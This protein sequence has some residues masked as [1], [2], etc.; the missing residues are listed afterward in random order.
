MARLSKKFLASDVVDGT[1][2]RFSNNEAF[3]LRNNADSADVE[4]YKLDT[5]D[6]FQFLT[7][8]RIS[9]TASNDNDVLTLKDLNQ[10]LEGLKPKAACRVATTA[11][12]DISSAPAAIDGITLVIGDRVL[13]KDQSVAAQNGIRIFSGAAG[14]MTRS[15]DM[16]S[17][18]PI[19]EVNGAYTAVQEGTDNEGKFFSQ[20]GTVTTIDVDPI[21]FVFFNSVTDLVGGDGIDITGNTISI[22]HDGEG[23][24]FNAGVLELEL[25]GAT[26]SKSATGIK[27]ADAG[28]GEAQLASDVDA[29]S[30]DIAVGYTPGA[31]TVLPGDTIQEALQKVDGTAGAKQDPVSGGDGIDVTADVVSVDLSSTPYLEFTSG[32]LQAKVSADYIS[33]AAGDVMDAADIKT[34]VDAVE[35]IANGKQDPISGADAIDVTADV[36]SLTLSVGGAT[37]PVT[38][39]SNTDIITT[40]NPD[41]TS[42][43]FTAQGGLTLGVSP[44]IN[45]GDSLSI[46][47]DNGDVFTFDVGFVFNVGGLLGLG[48]CTNIERNT[49][50]SDFDSFVHF[51]SEP[52]G[53]FDLEITSAPSSDS[54]LD[55][56]SGLK[57]LV[58]DDYASATSGELMDAQD[59][60]DAIAATTPNVAKETFV[61]DASDIS[62]G[63]VDLAQTPTAA[64]VV[65]IV[66]GAVPQIEGIDFSVASNRVTFLGDLASGGDAAL[67]DT[68]TVNIQYI[69]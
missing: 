31:G 3:R 12:I 42:L 52:E 2:L 55:Q 53:N 40:S 36:V 64:S 24:A 16:D 59:I 48:S 57:V 34:K 49:I 65:F 67:D 5:S 10:E 58:A 7:H 26:L 51:A 15:E 8:P 20:S 17:T 6:I 14:S 1:K 68:D 37:S 56:A 45:N 33:A 41:S 44:T 54:Y 19:N 66:Q 38:L 62:N 39:D 63:Y 21:N 47:D 69:Y 11:N 9:T 25:D 43:D 28:V 60:K 50:A 4:A 46:T 23:L 29:E 61:L 13:V 30:L 22:D 27:V 18:S 32:E 35:G